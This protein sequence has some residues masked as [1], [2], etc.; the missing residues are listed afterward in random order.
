M[1]AVRLH[2][3]GKVQRVGYRDWTESTARM[4]ELRGWVRNRRDDRS[5]EVL[6][7]GEATAVSKM[8]EACRRGPEENGARVDKVDVEPADAAAVP[9]GFRQLPTV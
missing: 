8:I 1:K 5:V 9:E 7:A 3:T 6:V 2:I 4:L